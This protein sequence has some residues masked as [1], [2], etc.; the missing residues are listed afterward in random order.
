MTGNPFEAKLTFQLLVPYFWSRIWIHLCEPEWNL[1]GNTWH[2]RPTSS[3]H[4][5]WL[6]VPEIIL[7]GNT[8][9]CPWGE[10]QLIHWSIFPPIVN[11]KARPSK[12][13]GYGLLFFI[14]SRLGHIS[15]TIGPTK[16]VHLSKFTGFHREINQ[17][18][19]K[20]IC[21]SISIT[22]MKEKMTWKFLFFSS[23]L[24]KCLNTN[25]KNKIGSRGFFFLPS[26]RLFKKALRLIRGPVNQL[27]LA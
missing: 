4:F 5:H 18:L 19:L 6:H 17:S 3:L 7:G 10:G 26:P 14:A 1:L 16:F 13:L 20:I 23:N 27:S 21:W 25:S 11:Y 8:Q 22:I 9:K 24:F 15:G 12:K 2:T